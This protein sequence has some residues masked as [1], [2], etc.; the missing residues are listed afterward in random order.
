MGYIQVLP[1]FGLVAD[2]MVGVVTTAGVS[3]A[4]VIDQVGELENITDDIVGMLSGE[5]SFL[6]SFPHR[7]K[8]LVYAGSV[9]AMWYGIA[10]GLI[11]AGLIAFA[12]L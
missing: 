6:S 1:E 10:V 5:G 2:P 8:S 7:E 4:P 3:L 12:L 9:T 11:V